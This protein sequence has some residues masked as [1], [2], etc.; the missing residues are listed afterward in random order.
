MYTQNKNLQAEG[1]EALYFMLR[2]KLENGAMNLEQLR[3][4]SKISSDFAKQTAT[5]TTRQDIQF[6]NISSVIV[7]NALT[8]ASCDNRVLTDY[9][10]I[11]D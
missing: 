7:I 9:V 2:I 3:A 11:F 1:D 5:F 4:V 8:A 10:P 6:H